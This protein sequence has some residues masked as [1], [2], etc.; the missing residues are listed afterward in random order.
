MTDIEA[1]RPPTPVFIL[2]CQIQFFKSCFPPKQTIIKS[3]SL[4]KYEHAFRDLI[5]SSQHQEKWKRNK[6]FHCRAFAAYIKILSHFG[7]RSN[8]KTFSSFLF[9]VFPPGKMTELLQPNSNVQDLWKSEGD[10]RLRK[11]LHRGHLD[12]NIQTK[13]NF[14]TQK[15]FPPL[16]YCNQSYFC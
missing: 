11:T 4:R 8:C 16:G 3:V 14:F 10:L 15:S 1:V 6:R 12:F 7:R 13:G 5:L 9:F 2:L